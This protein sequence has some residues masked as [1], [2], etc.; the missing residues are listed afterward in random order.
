MEGASGTQPV[1]SRQT[2]M[3][4]ACCFFEL[5][6]FFLAPRAA[7]VRACVDAVLSCT[8]GGSWHE[9]TRW[10]VICRPC[11]FGGGTAVGKGIWRADIWRWTFLVDSSTIVVSLS[12]TD[13][14][15]VTS[16][17]CDSFLFSSRSLRQIDT[18]T[19]W[20]WVVRQYHLIGVGSMV[21]CTVVMVG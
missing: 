13:S 15:L 18:L 6:Q 21:L 19:T 17:V 10:S 1:R 8:S 7:D 3:D 2:N 14:Q 11:A 5:E 16:S 9:E 20:V 4:A 12:S